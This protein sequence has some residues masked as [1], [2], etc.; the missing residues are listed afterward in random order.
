MCP[1]SR[2]GLST[3][4]FLFLTG[5]LSPLSASSK[6]TLR[7]LLRGHPNI[8]SDKRKCDLRGLGSSRS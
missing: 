7:S 4:R 1:R 3:S 8:T 5:D 6:S 2:E